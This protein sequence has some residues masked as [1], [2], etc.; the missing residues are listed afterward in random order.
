MNQSSWNGQRWGQKYYY[1]YYYRHVNPFSA[2]Y[3]SGSFQGQKSIFQLYLHWTAEHLHHPAP[4]G[5]YTVFQNN[6]RTTAGCHQHINGK[7]KYCWSCWLSAQEATC[8][9]KIKW[10]PWGHHKAAMSDMSSP[11]A[12]DI[13][14][15][16]EPL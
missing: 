2:W 14:I 8:I 15:W 7:K 5:V 16:G 1:Y 9:W 10:V 3:L 6:V 13:E 4:N 12:T 11:K